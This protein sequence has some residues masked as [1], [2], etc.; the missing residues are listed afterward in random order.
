MLGEKKLFPTASGS[1]KPNYGTNSSAELIKNIPS[2]VVENNF[3]EVVKA[4]KTVDSTCDFEK[5]KTKTNLI[6]Q[7]CNLCKKRFCFKHNLPEIHGCGNA[8]K[9]EE[10]KNFLKPVPL[11]TIRAEEEHTKAKGRLDSKLKEMQ[12]TRL[13]KA[14]GA[15]KKK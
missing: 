10:R 14:P 5:C 13:A 9:K 4:I 11:K 6:G 8:I 15:G 2:D 3:D 1:K 7:D 12:E